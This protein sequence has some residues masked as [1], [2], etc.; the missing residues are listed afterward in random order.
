[1][2]TALGVDVGQLALVAPPALEVDHRGHHGRRGGEGQPV[3]RERGD[4]RGH[5]GQALGRHAI[6][7]LALHAHALGR[8]VPQAWHRLPVKANFQASFRNDGG[9]SGG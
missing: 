3:D 8:Q 7:G 9:A 2:A 5:V 6:D 4:R 1:M